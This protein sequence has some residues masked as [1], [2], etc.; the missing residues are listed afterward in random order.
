M[1]GRP[2]NSQLLSPVPHLKPSTALQLKIMTQSDSVTVLG[3][4]HT[5]LTTLDE[6]EEADDEY[7]LAFSDPSEFAEAH[8]SFLLFRS[9]SP[10]KEQEKESNHGEDLDEILPA[11]PLLPPP[12]TSI[13][14]SSGWDPLPTTPQVGMVKCFGQFSVSARTPT[15]PCIDFCSPSWPLIQL[16]ILNATVKWVLLQCWH[17]QIRVQSPG[18]AVKPPCSAM[19]IRLSP[20]GCKKDSDRGLGLL[21]YLWWGSNCTR[22]N[23]SQTCA[24]SRRRTIM[25][26]NHELPSR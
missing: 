16:C 23:I 22:R 14:A 21:Q 12:L 26:R 18:Y 2:R 17:A 7:E 19:V 4:Q 24:P 8:R 1:I 13:V 15:S 6:A 3:H 11:P 20:G 5:S 25:M 9:K 10:S